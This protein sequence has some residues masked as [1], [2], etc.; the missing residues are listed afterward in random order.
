MKEY[1]GQRKREKENKE[2]KKSQEEGKRRKDE[3]GE[4]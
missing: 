4:R 2:V 3:G 1:D